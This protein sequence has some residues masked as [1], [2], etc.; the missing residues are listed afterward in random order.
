MRIAV[1]APDVDPFMESGIDQ[2]L[3]RRHWIAH[4]AITA[5]FPGRRFFTVKIAL[6]VLIKIRTAFAKKRIVIRRQ[7][8]FDFGVLCERS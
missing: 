1:Q 2:T 4:E 3:R 8:D 7:A 6:D 5:A